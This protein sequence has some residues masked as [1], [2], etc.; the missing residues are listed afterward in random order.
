MPESRD[1][2][3]ACTGSVEMGDVSGIRPLRRVL[4][5]VTDSDALR[6]FLQDAETKAKACEARLE[7]AQGRFKELME[8]YCQPVNKDLEVCLSMHRYHG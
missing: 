6:A 1:G 5:Q 8:F 7:A 3:T 2:E 4:S